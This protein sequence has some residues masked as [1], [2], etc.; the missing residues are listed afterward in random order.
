MVLGPFLFDDS[1][2]H[3][4]WPY[5]YYNHIRSSDFCQDTGI[6]TCV[7]LIVYSLMSEK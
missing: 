7:Y 3:K 4:V 5:P 6:E 2:V 1:G